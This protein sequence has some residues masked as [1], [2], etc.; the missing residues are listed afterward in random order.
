MRR[1]RIL[2]ATV[3]GCLAWG[4]GSTAAATPSPLYDSLPPDGTISVVSVGEESQQFNQFGNEV[5]L[6]KSTT[7]AKMSVTLVSHACQTGNGTDCHTDVGATFPTLFALNLYRHS[8]TNPN[9]GEVT[10]GTK[11]LTYTKTANIKFRPS[12]DPT[13]GDPTLYRGSD[14]NCYSGVKQN[15]VFDFPNRKLPIDVVWGV[16]FNTDHQGPSPIGGTGAPQDSLNFGL[17][18][19][20]KTGLNRSDDSVFWDTSTLALSCA[21]PTDGNSGPFVTGE[22]NRDGPCDGTTNSWAHLIPGAKFTPAG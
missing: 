13:C 9:T 18:A 14:G 11:I 12:A 4:V 19:A 8:T 3:V 22:F 5:I 2:V 1:L 21:D 20:V 6:T 16:S 17:T 7:V 10:P 15:V